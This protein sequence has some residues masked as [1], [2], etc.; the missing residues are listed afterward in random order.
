MLGFTGKHTEMEASKNVTKKGN[1]FSEMLERMVAYCYISPTRFSSNKLSSWV[2][3]PCFL[4]FNDLPGQSS[5]GISLPLKLMASEPLIEK[6]MRKTPKE[7]SFEPK[8]FRFQ[9]TSLRPL[10]EDKTN[11]LTFPYLILFYCRYRFI[12]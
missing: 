4:C 12:V 3:L 9:M 10:F 2:Y 6:Q 11:N 8:R 5:Y 7:G 1:C